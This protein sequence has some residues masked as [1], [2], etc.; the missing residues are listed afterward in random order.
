MLSDSYYEQAI[1]A[2]P[3]SDFY[4]KLLLS[5]LLAVAGCVLVLFV[6]MIGLVL[7]LAGIFM[8]YSFIGNRNLEYEYTLTN[9]SVEIA[10]IFNASKRKELMSFEL[11]QVKMIVPVDSNRI[12]AESFAKKRDYSSRT[13]EGKVIS[14]V[15]EK[16]GIKELVSLEPDEKTLE[17][18]KAYAKNKMY[19]IL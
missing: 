17:H 16:N 14:L 15:V 13:G 3:G 7:F 19:D 1:K 18:I 6:G 2:K 4:L 11:D 5:V 10:A 9:G 12:T 8:F